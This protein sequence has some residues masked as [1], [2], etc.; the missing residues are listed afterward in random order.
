VR[1]AFEKNFAD[2]VE[3]GAALRIFRGGEE[4]VSLCGGFCDSARSVPWNEETL[5][6]IWSATKGVAAACTLHAMQEAG[7]DLHTR[8]ADFWPEF[9]QAGKGA[10]TL[11]Q[12][13]SHR[14]GLCALEDPSANILDRESVVR[15]IE[16]QTPLLPVEAGPA[17]GPR[18]FGFVLDEI[19]RRLAGGESLAAY[20]RRV[21]A[22]PLDIDLWI[23][24]PENQ[25]SRVAT[26][27]PPR[28][29]PPA[30]GDELFLRAFTD[31][32]SLTRRAFA[33]PP[34]L[35]GISAMNNP[36]V[37]A[38]SLPSMGGIGS[39]RA[40]A[41]FYAMLA[42]G[43]EM[44]GKV[45]FK[46][47]T[48][49]WMSTRLTQGFDPVLQREMSFSAGFMMDPLDGNGRKIRSLLGPSLSAFGHAGA[50]GSLGFADPEQ[51]IGF[52]YVMNQM[53]SGVLPHERCTSLVRAFYEG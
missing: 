47:E 50:G 4:V 33:S 12:V 5:V 24:L 18:V 30:A 48:L 52:G 22:E 1:Q 41:K 6:L 16:K 2:G 37:R 31:P 51:C 53:E 23:G 27:L 9:A 17:Y 20:W 36:R 8:V 25:N 49:E 28:A 45:F 29:G 13:F 14:A 40:L 15:A 26:I 42:S 11:G 35:S 32:N 44:D 34:G 38:A 46:N 43:G 19:L 7:A 21:F 10:L 39:A 3:V